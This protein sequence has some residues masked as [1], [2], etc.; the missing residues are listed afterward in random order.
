MNSP[1]PRP[2]LPYL[3][4]LPSPEPRAVKSELFTAV[5]EGW[6]DTQVRVPGLLLPCPMKEGKQSV[7]PVVRLS[8]EPAQQN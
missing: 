8:C 2:I 6:P 1:P 3:Y 7:G 5:W 4:P